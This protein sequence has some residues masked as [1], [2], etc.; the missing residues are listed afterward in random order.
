MLSSCKR[1]HASGIEPMRTQLILLST[2]ILVADLSWAA[3]VQDTD[4]L[5]KPS[6]DPTTLFTTGANGSIHVHNVT[7]PGLTSRLLLKLTA[8]AAISPSLVTLAVRRSCPL[9]IR[10]R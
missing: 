5:G 4:E 1:I 10:V 6:T 8:E 7:G 9:M 3:P 2:C